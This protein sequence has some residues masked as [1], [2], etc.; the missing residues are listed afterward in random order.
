MLTLNQG[1]IALDT[2]FDWTGK[3]VPDANLRNY[4]LYVLYLLFPLVLLVG[5]FIL[6]SV[7]VL[8]VLGEIKPMSEST[9]L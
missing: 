2:A 9:A 1:Y 3:F 4:A 5:F 7:L 8:H 6:E